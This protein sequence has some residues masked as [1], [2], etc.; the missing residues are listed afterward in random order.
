MINLTPQLTTQ[1]LTDPMQPEPFRVKRVMKESYDT[2]TLEMEPV[3]SER[4]FTFAPGQF[5]MLYIFG[6]GEIPISIS[7]DP[8]QPAMLVHTTRIVGAVTKAMS[9]LKAGDVLGVRGPFG[10]GWPVSAAKG[11]DVVLVAGGIGLA[12]LRPVLYQMLAHRD[13]YGKVVLLYGC[14]SP[15]DILFRKELEKWRARFDLEIFVTVDYGDSDWHGNVGVVT[16]LIPKAP[17]DALNAVTMVCGPEVMMRFTAIEL[18]K[19]GVQGESIALSMERNMKCAIGL[20]GHCQF[21]PTFICKDGP[22][23]TYPQLQSWLAQWEV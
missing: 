12:P 14:R 1:Q 9:K 7:G 22:V 5:N 6:V 11:C 4:L 10:T 20:C 3:N 19:R 18:Q 17:F 8:N 15:E 21:G 2:F 13:R 16:K 23:F